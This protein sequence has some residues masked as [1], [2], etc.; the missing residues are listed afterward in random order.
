MLFLLQQAAWIF[1]LV[2]N[3]CQKFRKGEYVR[4]RCDIDRKKVWV[5]VKER[6]TYWLQVSDING[7]EDKLWGSSLSLSWESKQFRVAQPKTKLWKF[8]CIIN[9][10][11]QKEQSQGFSRKWFKENLKTTLNSKVHRNQKLPCSA[12]VSTATQTSLTVT[13]LLVILMAWN[14]VKRQLN[15]SISLH[16]REPCYSN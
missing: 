4:L 13:A 15:I 8:S 1:N 11:L 2:S 12:V 3:L 14:L 6:E 16:L 10:S 5:C 7:S 9:R